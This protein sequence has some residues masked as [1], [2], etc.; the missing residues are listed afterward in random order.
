MEVL[1]MATEK[2]VSVVFDNQKNMWKV[3]YWWEGSKVNHFGWMVNG[4]VLRFSPDN[5]GA[6]EALRQVIIA[7]M[8]PGPDGIV[9][10]HPGMIKT[11]RTNPRYAFPKFTRRWLDKHQQ[12]ADNGDKTQDYVR[13]LN[14]FNKH[15]WQKLNRYNILE[16]DKNVISKFYTWLCTHDHSKSYRAMIMDSLRSIVEKAYRE[17]GMAVPEDMWPHYRPGKTARKRAPKVLNDEQQNKVLKHVPAKHYPMVIMFFYHGLRMCE[18]RRLTWDTV[19]LEKG[20]VTVD[21]AKGG[22]DRVI[23]LEPAVLD[24]LKSVPKMVHSNLVFHNDGRPYSKTKMFKVIRV[25]LNKAGFKDYTPNQ[26]GRHSAA[27]SYLRRGAST[28]EVQYIL[29]HADIT[30]TERYTHPITINQKEYRRG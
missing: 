18:V 6:A 23:L 12:D 29:G 14:Y 19:D 25:A 8:L 15:Y 7:K 17:N 21:T 2:K 4:Q 24:T 27:T 1:E 10:F 3:Q 13:V 28:R 22:K 30:T 5:K 9:H 16:I 20:T 11:G 26:A